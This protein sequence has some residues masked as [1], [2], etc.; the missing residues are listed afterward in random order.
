M[1]S[2]HSVPTTPTWTNTTWVVSPS[3]TVTVWRPPIVVTADVGTAS[4]DLALLVTID[5]VPVEPLF[6]FAFG[7]SRPTTTR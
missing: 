7:V 2:V 6:S 3:T 1:I 4:A 5:T